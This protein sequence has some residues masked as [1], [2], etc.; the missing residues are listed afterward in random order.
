MTPARRFAFVLAA[1]VPALTA[2]TETATVPPQ[3]P[4]AGDL[5]AAPGVC[6]ILSVNDTYRIEPSPDG[7]GGMARLRS[8]RLRLEA[9]YPDLILLHA[10]DFLFPSLLS[11]EYLGEQMI[12]VMNHLDGSEGFDSRMLVTFGNHEFDNDN[13]A[14]L[15][16]RVAQSK[17]RWLSSNIE[18]ERSREGTFVIGTQKIAE[19]VILSCGGYKVGVFA[20]TTADRRPFYVK[21]FHPPIVVARERS[22]A[23]RARGADIVVGLTHLSIDTDADLMETLGAAGPDLIVGGHEHVRQTRSADTGRAAADE[24]D[25]RSVYKADSDAHT[26]NLLEI[27]KTPFGVKVGHRWLEVGPKDP[28]PDPAVESLVNGWLTRHETAYCEKRMSL[29]PGCLAE[30]LTVTGSEL[31]AD[32][33]E[34]RRFETSLGDYLLD[35]ALAAYA[36]DG[37]QAAFINAGSLRLNY[38]VA[39][40][41]TITRRMIEEL[42]AYQVPLH[43]IEIS[44]ATL[45]KVLERATSEWTGHGHFLQ[46]AGFAFRFDPKAG[47]VSNLTLLRPAP[48]PILPDDRIK[49]VVNAYLIDPSRGQ[50]RYTMIGPDNV[51]DKLGP[52]LALGP[53]LKQ[54]T[55]EALKAAGP[56]GIAPTVE[57]RICNTERPGPCLAK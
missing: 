15:N 36:A 25:Q 48:R 17:F 22:A 26:A 54:L 52:D 2:C 24:G 27:T 44:G 14:V 3:A 9:Q 1:V 32:E 33:L 40:G 28:P 45:Q 51:I 56:A 30:K 6:A 34:M 20:L 57:G 37:A 4:P 38:N 19:D 43:L 13:P 31:V 46:I 11:R 7:T 39:K 55:L 35:L 42:F 5:E 10:G 47:K 21:E 41:V 53:E 29:G 50:D 12:D 49:V 8:L 23:L 16:A 18:F